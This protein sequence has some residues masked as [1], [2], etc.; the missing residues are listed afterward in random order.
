M[1]GTHKKEMISDTNLL[2]PLWSKALKTVVLL[3]Y[4][5]N[6]ISSKVILK[7][8]FKVRNRWKPSLNHLHIWGC[9]PIVRIYHPCNTP[10]FKILNLIS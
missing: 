8:P 9:P 1:V 10:Y 2:L 5:L 6:R 7:R 3:V 4:M